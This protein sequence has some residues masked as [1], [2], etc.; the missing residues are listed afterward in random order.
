MD[1]ITTAAKRFY[2]EHETAWVGV[3]GEEPP[4]ILRLES[5]AS[6]RRSVIKAL[7]VLEWQPDNRRPFSIVEVPFA[8][9][10]SY[11]AAAIDHVRKDIEEL[12]KGLTEDG[13]TR[14]AMPARPPGSSPE[15]AVAHFEVLARHVA[16]ALDG[17]VVV[18]A[19]A[20]LLDRGG[21]TKVIAAM[22]ARRSANAPLRLDVFAPTAPELVE[23]LPMA[24]RFVVDQTAL[25]SHLRDLGAQDSAGPEPSMPPLAEDKRKAIEAELGQ[26]IVSRHAGVTLKNLFFDGGLALSQNRGKDALRKYRAARILAEATGLKREALVATMGVGSCYATLRNDRGADAAYRRAL[27]IAGELER[28]DLQAQALFGLGFV[29]MREGRFAQ[30]KPV[31]ERIVT[32]VGADNPLHGEAR[33]LVVACENEDPLHGTPT[34]EVR[35]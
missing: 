6:E 20:Q 16:T 1:P 12:D 4:P 19:P 13:I 15:E 14:T 24:A 29:A 9:A 11:I 32:L 5:D 25:L 30:A 21:F 17:L 28:P 34:H 8:D 31:Y 22:K 26:P 18:L 3:P 33:R 35:P 27:V 2:R 10:S 23:L 7:R